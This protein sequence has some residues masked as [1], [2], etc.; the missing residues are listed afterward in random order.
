MKRLPRIARPRHHPR[1]RKI[2]QHPLR[3]RIFIEY[4][5]FETQ[6]LLIGRS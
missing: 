5:A 4:F 1:Q 3:R 2:R 6:V